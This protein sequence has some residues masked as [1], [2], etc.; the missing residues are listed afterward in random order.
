M[1]ERQAVAIPGPESL[2]YGVLHTAAGAH[3][4]HTCVVL[5]NAGF[6]GRSGPN[7]LYVDLASGLCRPGLD[8]LRLDC[9]GLGESPGKLPE[10][11]PGELA[12][13]FNL[14]LLAGDAIAAVDYI[15]EHL[16]P[17]RIVLGG[18]CGGATTS[19]F[20]AQMDP[21]VSGLL[22]MGFPV[23]LEGSDAGD[24]EPGPSQGALELRRA[25]YARKLR[26]PR[27]WLRLARSRPNWRAL[28]SVLRESARRPSAVADASLHPHT[29]T[30]A[31]VAF[32]DCARRGV[33]TLFVFGEGDVRLAD[34]RAEFIRKCAAHRPEWNEAF[35]LA[36]VPEARHTFQGP[37]A[38]R[39]LVTSV[40]GWLG[41]GEA[42]PAGSRTV[43]SGH[44]PGNRFPQRRSAGADH[45]ATTDS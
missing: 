22:L 12:L 4:P 23:L 30:R 44:C 45:R 20:A 41:R 38:T 25:E 29:N 39:A 26:D 6:R 32:G 18:L 2:L 24:G 10:G 3:P 37:D 19:L 28:W 31:L 42:Q 16:G 34:F 43:P 21:R 27:A 17:S 36:A 11:T 33:A 7:D 13:E 9:R 1:E 5:T 40:S 8:V 35:E 14:G 15:A